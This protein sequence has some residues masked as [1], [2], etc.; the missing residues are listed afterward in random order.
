MCSTPQRT[1]I[2]RRADD[3]CGGPMYLSV[4]FI[5]SKPTCVS[6]IAS[7]GTDK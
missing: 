2:A 7:I 5:A 4:S 3:H 1:G 6:D